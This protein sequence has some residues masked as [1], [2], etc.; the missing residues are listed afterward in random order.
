MATK[1]ADGKFSLAY[2]LN[3]EGTKDWLRSYGDF[4]RVAITAV[5][6]FCI[7]YCIFTIFF[8]K[9]PQGNVNKPEGHQTVTA[10]PFS[11]VG[12]VTQTFESTSVQKVEESAHKWWIPHLYTGIAVGGRVKSN[13]SSVDLGSAEPEIR[14]D[15]LGLRWD[16]N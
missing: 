11:T 8:P 9:K 2:F 15:F 4:I 14:A 5:I 7:G 10:T 16:W 13:G 12:E 1:P 6:I 3:G